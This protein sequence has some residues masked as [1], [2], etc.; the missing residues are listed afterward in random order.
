MRKIDFRMVAALVVFTLILSAVSPAVAVVS[1]D[2]VERPDAHGR[3]QDKR[4]HPLGKKHDALKARAL[5]DKVRGGSGKSKNGGVYEITPG[6]F[7][8][9][10]LAGTDM[11]WTVP[12]EFADLPHNSIPE[13][14]RTVDNST[15]WE[16]DFSEAY[17]DE[18]LYAR[19]S[20]VNSMAEYFLEQSSG[21]YTVD[22]D[23]AAW[24]PVPGDHTVYD[25]GTADNDTSRNVW[26]FLQDSLDG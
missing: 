18:M 20:A 14:D 23:C 10:E 5:E 19:G 25:D 4:E 17:Y 22:G 7:V 16:P 24:V 21:R 9:L 12:G 26:L 8:E 1:R 6:E 15:I 2:T 3:R 13:P 11:V